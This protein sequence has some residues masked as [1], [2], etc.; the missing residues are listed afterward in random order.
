MI[1]KHHILLLK[2]LSVASL[3][4]TMLIFLV[5]Y[6]GIKDGIHSL[7]LFWSLYVVCI[8]GAH[9]KILIGVPC[10]RFFNIVPST[11]PYIWSFM[12][13]LNILSFIFRPEIYQTILP[14]QLL[15]LIITTPYPCWATFATAFPGTFY[16]SL[17]GVHHYKAR[18]AIIRLL[19]II[20]GIIAFL[21]FTH[22]ELITLLHTVA[23]HIG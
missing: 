13:V 8:P 18:H 7:M 16:R 20:G 22:K 11:E 21:F 15:Y 14:T 23:H 3:F 2:F 12:V 4:S 1:R 10:G 5:S 6:H 9:G 17:V 19:L